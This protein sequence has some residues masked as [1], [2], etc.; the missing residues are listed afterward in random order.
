MLGN[1]KDFFRSI[2]GVSP[3]AIFVLAGLACFLVT[4]FLAGRPFSWV[5][6]LLPGLLLSVVVEALEIWMHYGIQGLMAAEAASLGAIL[7]RHGR[8]VVLMNLAPVMVVIVA[9]LQGH[10][11]GS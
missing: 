4:C 2:L 3:D 9:N 7:L 10:M 6:G 8:D 5:W 1:L 11:A